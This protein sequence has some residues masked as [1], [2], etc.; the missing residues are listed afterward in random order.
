[1]R[2]L[3]LLALALA[4]WPCLGGAPR[5]PFDRELLGNPGFEAGVFAPWVVEYGS[6]EIEYGPSFPW[7]TP[8][9]GDWLFYGGDEGAV[10]S[11]RAWQEVDL[12]REGF[13]AATLDAGLATVNAEAWL[14]SWANAGSFDDQVFY[15][16]RFL[17]P[18]GI[19]LGSVRTLL[20]GDDDWLQRRAAAVLPPGTR[21]LRV[22]IEARFRAGLDNDGMADDT[23]VKLARI[24]TSPPTLTKQPMLQDVRLDAM[25]ILWETDGNRARH[26]VEWGPA[27]AGLG[28][29]HAHV[30][31]TQVDAQHFVHK[32][33]L[34]GLSPETAYDYRVVS[35]TTA[36]PI[37][38][39]RTAPLP[40][41]PY[42]IAW[43]A[44]NQNGPGVLGQHVIH[45]AARNPDL[46]IAAG[47]VVQ[48]GNVL[49]EWQTQWFAPLEIAFFAQTRPVVFARGNHDKEHAFAYAYSALP[50]NESWY[51]FS[52][53]NAFFV[54]LDT[55]A[56][57]GVTSP[58]QDQ[59][60]F[61]IQALESPEALVAE[62]RIVVFHRPPYTNLW[63]DPFSYNGETWVRRDW[64]PVFEAKS[65]DLVV[66]GHAHAYQRGARNGVTYVI[67]GGGGGALDTWT[68]PEPWAF[69]D[70]VESA[71][72]YNLMDV[73]GSVLTWTAYDLDDQVLDSFQIVN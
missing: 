71:W 10:A 69:F 51:A 31:T 32:A 67:V 6:C 20:V 16:V 73:S 59:L 19:E 15:R 27:G 9:S 35:E 54:V 5:Q 42:R 53:G 57:T 29:V 49:E 22:E 60:A 18:A 37:Y 48:N 1:M 2:P 62:F 45:M 13:L 65:V 40:S 44:D 58:E 63:D 12:L 43:I 36:S 38:T 4:V 68:P 66:S 50:G 21:R 28:Q 47:D 64:V 30:E 25:T 56:R 34:S 26:T 55:E 72:H 24:E 7:A 23:S 17:D 39:F 8:H 33:V 61:L 46:L 41:S 11:C 3:H 14:R 52:Y 70:V